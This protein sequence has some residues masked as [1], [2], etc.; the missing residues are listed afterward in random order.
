MFPEPFPGSASAGAASDLVNVVTVSL[1][2]RQ[3]RTSFRAKSSSERA[4]TGG[5]GEYLDESLTPRCTSFTYVARRRCGASCRGTGAEAVCH[6][7]SDQTDM[8]ARVAPGR[9]WQ[10]EGRL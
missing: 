3:I 7:S 6:L 2:A 9:A 1:S 5:K 10:P 8:V 4:A